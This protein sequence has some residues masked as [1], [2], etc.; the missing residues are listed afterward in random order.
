MYCENGTILKDSHL[1]HKDNYLQIPTLKKVR[2]SLIGTLVSHSDQS[3]KGATFEHV[4]TLQ[5]IF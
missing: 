5:P 1:T 3:R 4:S 2:S